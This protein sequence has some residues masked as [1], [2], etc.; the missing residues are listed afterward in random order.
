[1][2]GTHRGQSTT[3]LGRGR[4]RR[5]ALSGLERG[6]PPRRRGG[7]EETSKLQH[8]VHVFWGILLTFWGG[9][10]SVCGGASFPSLPFSL[11]SFFFLFAL[12]AKPQ[13]REGGETGE[14][15]SLHTAEREQT[16]DVDNSHFWGG[17]VRG[18]AAG[19]PASTHETGKTELSS[20][21]M[22]LPALQRV[23]LPHVLF[24]LDVK[25]GIEMDTRKRE[26]G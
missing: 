16:L 5:G 18:A 24:D 6:L 4:A 12:E 13:K 10:C 7:V 14:R 22:G 20:Q 8:G 25:R 19:Q 1:M 3:C 2:E 9:G 21:S 17:T 23:F 11:L 26:R 15:G